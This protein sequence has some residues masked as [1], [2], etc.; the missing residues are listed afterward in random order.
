[1]TDI[2]TSYLASPQADA[3]AIAGLVALATAAITAFITGLVAKKNINVQLDLFK[4]KII[5]DL[6]LLEK[7]VQ[8]DLAVV[9]SKVELEV[10]AAERKRVAEFAGSVLAD[11]YNAKS[12]FK[13]ARLSWEKGDIKKDEQGKLIVDDDIAD[14]ALKPFQY[15]RDREYIL[16]LWSQSVPMR[17][18]SSDQRHRCR[19]ILLPDAMP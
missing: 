7:R 12:L 16:F 19:L 11:F 6:D 15:L 17:P 1:M 9:K 5:A 2:V 10:S 3:A 14:M 13:S 4:K 8:G 18:F